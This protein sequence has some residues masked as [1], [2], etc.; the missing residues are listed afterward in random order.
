M[1]FHDGTTALANAGAT[2]FV[3]VGPDR[4]L[5]GLVQESV[6]GEDVLAVAPLRRERPQE[7][8]LLS[9]LAQLH[10]SGRT[11][12]WGA[13]LERNSAG[14]PLRQVD[15]PTYPFQHRHYWLH[16]PAATGDATGFGQA[17]DEHPLLGAMVALPGSDGLVL[18]GRLSTRTH[19]WLADHVIL[20]TVVL[21]GTAFVE[22]AAH[23]GEL[24]G[25]P[26]IDELTIEAPLVVPERGGVALQVTV[27]GPD[28]TGRRSLAV[29][30]RPE[31]AG[32]AGDDAEDVAWTRHVSGVLSPPKQQRKPRIARWSWG[33]RT[34]TCGHRTAPSPS[35]SRLSIAT[36]PPWGTATE[37]RSRA[38]GPSGG[39]RT[40][41][42]PRS[43][44]TTRRP[45]TRPPTV[46]TRP[47]WT[48]PCTAPTSSPPTR[49][50]RTRRPASR[51]PGPVC[52]SMRGVRR[53]CG[54]ASPLRTV[55]LPVTAGLPVA[56][57]SVVG[58]GA[59]RWRS[60]TRPVPRWRRSPR[61]CPARSPPDGWPP[62]ERTGAPSTV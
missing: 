5:T 61:W 39:T 34:P 56:G 16:A 15:L 9:C 44:W 40:R 7:P 42:T 19:P 57:P 24:T 37:R 30:S 60:P 41:C 23:A 11:V 49:F 8:E 50:R 55:A 21:P 22:L 4:T 51:S 14:Q 17:V 13:V 46:C 54:Y 26:A 12:R 10:V 33:P 47:C 28:G 36:S 2:V 62:P 6:T 48:P 18:T 38:C 27:G 35:T 32:D 29:H 52:G 31:D 1:R 20:D 45:S 53:A 25:C 43:R 58:P 3:E 59:S